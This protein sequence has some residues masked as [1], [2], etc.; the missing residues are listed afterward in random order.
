MT[1]TVLPFRPR[2]APKTRP[3]LPP[4]I[5]ETPDW[6]HCQYWCTDCFGGETYLFDTGTAIS[7]RRHV[8]L[9]YAET[10]ADVEGHEIDV[11]IEVVAVED[12]DEGFVDGA[13]IAT[14]LG[15]LDTLDLDA[16][17]RIRDA[18]DAALHH[19][20]QPLNPR[21]SSLPPRGGDR[22]PTPEAS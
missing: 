18:F 21:S 16:V 9:V 17:R 5:I 11:R 14:N 13:Y 10:V 22:V 7:T 3:Q 15:E 6:G 2:T 19:A 4:T 8:G 12:P 20:G 1:A